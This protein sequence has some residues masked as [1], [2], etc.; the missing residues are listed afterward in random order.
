MKFLSFQLHI[1]LQF[2]VW[3]HVADDFLKFIKNAKRQV[4]LH[5]EHYKFCFLINT[6][7][8]L[9]WSLLH[10]ADYPLISF[11]GSNALLMI[12]GG[13]VFRY[14]IRSSSSYANI[15]STRITF[16]IFI[17]F[18]ASTHESIIFLPSLLVPAAYF[19]FFYFYRLVLQLSLTISLALL[20][21][22]TFFDRRH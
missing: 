8:A 16:S 12:F 9:F 7:I 21:T 19:F 18:M 4:V 1:F 3:K 10:N 6:F 2:T 22:N 17:P 14:V 15:Y 13:D 11:F 20:S 5:H